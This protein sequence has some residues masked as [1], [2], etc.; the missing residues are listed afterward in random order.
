MKHYRFAVRKV[1]LVRGNEIALNTRMT[2]GVDVRDNVRLVNCLS[3][4]YVVNIHYW[5]VLLTRNIKK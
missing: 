3:H 5:N 2:D 1:F 4:N